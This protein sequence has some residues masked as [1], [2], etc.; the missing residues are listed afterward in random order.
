MNTRNLR[1]IYCVT[2][3][4]IAFAVAFVLGTPLNLVFGPAMGGFLNSIVTAMIIAIGCKGIERFPYA[5]VIWVAFSVP[6]I[7]TLTMGPPGPYKPLIALLT[8][9]AME[10][11]FML[12]GRKAWSYFLTGGIMSIVMTSSILGAMLLLSLD[13]QATSNLLARIWFVLPIYFFLGGIGMLLG[14]NIFNKRISHLDIVRR[15][16]SLE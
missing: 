9:L 14:Y 15:I 6:A 16:N 2:M 4:G 12:L 5:T 8:G 1:L 13:T 3:G 7:F 10:I 11:C